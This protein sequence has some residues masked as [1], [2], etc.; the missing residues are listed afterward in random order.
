MPI[1]DSPPP[2]GSF[3]RPSTEATGRLGAPSHHPLA[4]FTHRDEDGTLLRRD[5]NQ[6]PVYR[7]GKQWFLTPEG[8]RRRRSTRKGWS[9]VV[10]TLPEP[11]LPPA[12]SMPGF[13]E[14][15]P[16]WAARV[17]DNAHAADDAHE[18]GHVEGFCPACAAIRLAVMVTEPN[19]KPDPT[20]PPIDRAALAALV[21]V[22]EDFEQRAQN[23]VGRDS[24]YVAIADGYGHAA[25]RL[26]RDILG[27]EV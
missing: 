17:C 26:R 8:E 4:I 6:E 12:G 18:V 5:G 3:Q 14:V 24:R 20:A 16:D 25:R 19:D 15:Q 21:A 10:E 13:V 7:D 11:V 27:E 9:D 22:V 2:P 1:P 23:P